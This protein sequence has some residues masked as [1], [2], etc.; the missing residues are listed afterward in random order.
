ME[1]KHIAI[2][3][4]KDVSTWAE[5]NK[6]ELSETYETRADII[7]S[8]I[9]AQVELNIPIITI[10]LLSTKQ[11]FSKI[12]VIVDSLTKFFE[13]LAHDS[14]IVKN[15]I[16]VSVIG[17]WYNLPNRLVE[18]IKDVIDETKDF[19]KF[20]LNLCIHYHGKEEILDAAR[21]IS[22]KILSERL[23][24]DSITEETI[25]GDLYTSYFLAPDLMIINGDK[26]LDGFLL[27]DASD[28]V[29]YFTG[30]HWPDFDIR[31]FNKA[32]ELFKLVN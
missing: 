10:Y 21:L 25:K 4:H 14:E 20:F 24:P 31:D 30:K 19:D 8:L 11:D 9:R 6:K 15:Q 12:D 23:D 1:P 2:S 32:V 16:K 7:N 17:K 13:E 27:W 3:L 26:R 18:A 22:R 28:A 5:T 29:V